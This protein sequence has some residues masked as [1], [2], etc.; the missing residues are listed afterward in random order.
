MIPPE[1]AS[2]GEQNGENFSF[3]APSSEGR[4]LYVLPN[5]RYCSPWLFG[6][7]F[8]LSRFQA[9]VPVWACAWDSDDTNYFY[10]GLQNGRTLVC[11]VRV[12][13]SH[14][15]ELTRPGGGGC[16]ITSLS[17]VPLCRASSLKYVCKQPTVIRRHHSCCVQL[18]WPAHEHAGCWVLLGEECSL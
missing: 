6:N 10:C 2:Q 13:S 15:T 14:V 11:D 17:Y 5:Q 16:P 8:L 12:T 18:W 4:G 1:R 3:I 7:V 9:P